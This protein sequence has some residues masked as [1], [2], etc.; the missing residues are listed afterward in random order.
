MLRKAY[1]NARARREEFFW[2]AIRRFHGGILKSFFNALI[3]NLAIRDLLL[4]P[5]GVARMPS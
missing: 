4:L 5:H 3:L 2:Q 1:N